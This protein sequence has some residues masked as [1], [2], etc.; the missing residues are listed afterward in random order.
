MGKIRWSEEAEQWLRE[1]RDYISLDKPEAA[2]RTVLGIYE[3]AQ[4]LRSFP[5]RGSLHTC[6]SGETV[7]ILLY[8]HYRI[9]Y[10]VHEGGDI[11]VIGVFHGSL[12][13]QRYL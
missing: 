10:T 2:H 1:I 11:F 3:K 9:V 13:I 7:R 12:D 4:G 8:G 5:E 6:S